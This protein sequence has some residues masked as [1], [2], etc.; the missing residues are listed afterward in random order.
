MTHLICEEGC[1]HKLDLAANYCVIYPLKFTELDI[2]VIESNCIK[3]EKVHTTWIDELMK[4][5]TGKR[6]FLLL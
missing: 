1:G 2:W 5:C 3:T 6:S 4:L